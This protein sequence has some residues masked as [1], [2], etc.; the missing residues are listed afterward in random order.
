MPRY[1]VRLTTSRG[2]PGVVAHARREGDTVATIHTWGADA[3]DALA[4]QKEYLRPFEGP[5]VELVV[6]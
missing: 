5:N 3:Y 4:R 6:N 1:F 2:L